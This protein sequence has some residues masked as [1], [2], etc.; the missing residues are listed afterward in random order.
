M[1]Y[2]S[3]HEIWASMYISQISHYGYRNNRTYAIQLRNVH[4]Y[5]NPKSIITINY[6]EI[7]VSCDMVT[8][9]KCYEMFM[10]KLRVLPR[11]KGFVD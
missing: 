7:C 10:Q 11:N 9:S 3:L 5:Y 8:P 6:P 2:F 1:S 4:I